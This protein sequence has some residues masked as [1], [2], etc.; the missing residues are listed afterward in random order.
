MEQKIHQLFLFCQSTD[1]NTRKYAENELEKLETIEEYPISLVNLASITTTEIYIRQTSLIILKKYVLNHWSCVFEEFRGPIPNQHTKNQIRNILLELISSDSTVIRNAA[2][3]V[4]SKIATIDWPDEWPELFDSIL[5]KLSKG[6]EIEIHGGL[7]VLKELIDDV[8]TGEHFFAISQ[9][10]L[11]I[12]YNISSNELY[13]IKIRAQTLSVFKSCIDSLGMI[14][15]THIEII[16]SF[17][18][19][20]LDS[21]IDL[22]VTIISRN[23]MT[24]LNYEFI[25]IKLNT[26]KILHKLRQIFLY[27]LVKH[28]PNI[29]QVLWTEIEQI[30]RIYFEYYILNSYESDCENDSDGESI[31]LAELLTEEF[32]FVQISLK[33]KTIQ[34][35]LNFENYSK[36]SLFNKI[37]NTFVFYSQISLS[38]VEK[39]FMENFNS[40]IEDE[41][42]ENS[43]YTIRQVSVD[44]IEEFSN[45]NLT[46]TSIILMGEFESIIFGL[47]SQWRYTEAILFVI[48]R[49]LENLNI[50]EKYTVL[51]FSLSYYNA[52]KLPDLLR[53]RTIFILGQLSNI[54]DKDQLSK[55]FSDCLLMVFSESTGVI[56]LASFKTIQRFCTSLP[57]EY[58]KP[59]QSQII[60][61]IEFYIFQIHGESLILLL[62]ILFSAV[63]IDQDIVL[64]LKSTIIPILFKIVTYNYGDP[65]LIGIVQ[66]IFEDLAKNVSNFSLFCENILLPLKELLFSNIY[67]TL[68][69][70]LIEIAFDLLYSL[71]KGGSSSLPLI[72]LEEIV[73]RLIY[74]MK[75]YDS[76]EVLQSAEEVLRQIILKDYNK[77]INLKCETG[78]SIFDEIINIIQ[79]LLEKS[80]SESASFFLGPLIIAMIYK[81]KED[82]GNHLPRLLEAIVIR[83]TYSSSPRFCQELLLVF[84]HLA[85]NQA[86]DVVDFLYNIKLNNV[87]GLEILSKL[88]SENVDII[89]GHKNICIN[90]VAMAN[91]FMLQDL[92]L[93]NIIV[94]G[95]LIINDSKEIITRS[96]LKLDSQEY[97]FVSFPVKIIKILL[98]EFSTFT[99]I[100]KTIGKIYQITIV[101]T[102]KERNIKFLQSRVLM[103]IEFPALSDYNDNF[104][105]DPLN[106]L[107]L[108]KFL[109]DF[110]KNIISNNIN[111][112]KSMIPYLTSEESSLLDLITTH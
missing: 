107:D 31:N 72:F 54:L 15:K 3:H 33:N 16:N 30:K 89:H 70:Q 93:S 14:K 63:K 76:N 56:K 80:V 100:L 43:K 12:L 55:V 78:V 98:R 51:N 22:F 71:I 103:F 35:S 20:I 88:W 1:T 106:D 62:E 111:N 79:I 37:I 28:L 112:I 75:N 48:S 18:T 64:S 19:K 26:V 60:N 57:L 105:E 23:I 29:F 6:S 73:P 24:T 52:E 27:Q 61:A 109:T 67:N 40:F 99:D 66:D 82:F 95:D 81:A 96:K 38:Q 92:R 74:I 9:N 77:L 69:T 86:K 13:S 2:A 41:L 59:F 25:Y 50:S 17:V 42:N 49:I 68:E 101:I 4:I 45:Y 104:I 53:A 102:N 46:S 90:S 110:F 10:L 36:D 94:K 91:L 97:T 7:K 11:S 34:K 85:I 87:S 39:E 44:L 58:L 47:D 108:E 5:F 83:L 65:Y 8:F 84:A 32:L 21:W